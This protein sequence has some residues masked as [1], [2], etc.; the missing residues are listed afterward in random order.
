M[1]I[2]TDWQLPKLRITTSSERSASGSS[3]SSGI[4]NSPTDRKKRH[5]VPPEPPRRRSLVERASYE[6]LA[7]QETSRFERD[8]ET[9]D[10]LGSGEFGNVIK[11]RSKAGNDAQVYAIKKS[12]RFE[13][14]KH[15]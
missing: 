11:V 8:F 4:A 5:V 2:Y 14:V 7:V 15:R 3:T 6:T 13:G 1:M 10:E 12:K 9:V